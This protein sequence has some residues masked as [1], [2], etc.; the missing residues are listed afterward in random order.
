[1]KARSILFLTIVFA[2][3]VTSSAAHA[4][5][6]DDV[7]RAVSTIE[8]F[9]EIPESAIPPRVLRDAKGLAII[10]VTKAGFIVSGRGGTGVVVARNDKG[11]SGPSAIGTG[12]IGVGFQA[13][14][15]VSEYVIILNT[16]EAVSAFSKGGNVT[17]GGNLSAAVGP[18]GRSAEAGVAPQAA[19]Y[20]YSR[21]QGI[22]AGISLEG[23]VIA[24]RYEANEAYY[25]K[26][27]FPVD[28]L[29]GDVKPPDG[30]KKL[31]DILA[32]Y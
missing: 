3:C 26:P 6:Q 12:G 5:L 19:I 13:G 4:D 11:W 18:V 16:P 23:T 22:F 2:L 9:E 20:T 15:Q 7:D 30:A 32:K 24:T 17:L 28:I 14:V 21:N 27:V 10:T 25:G 8:R 1:M 31:L 29:A